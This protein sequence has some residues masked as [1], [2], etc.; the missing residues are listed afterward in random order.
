MLQT[1]LANFDEAFKRLLLLELLQRSEAGHFIESD[2]KLL[3]SYSTEKV[4]SDEKVKNI[5]GAFSGFIEEYH[6][7]K[8]GKTIQNW[9]ELYLRI[10]R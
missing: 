8:H 10:V 2:A 4:A 1:V 7:R 3:L 6:L 9:I 5:L